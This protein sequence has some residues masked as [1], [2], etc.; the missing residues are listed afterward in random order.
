[1]FTDFWFCSLVAFGDFFFNSEKLKNIVLFSESSSL[2]FSVKKS[3]KKNQFCGYQSCMLM[4]IHLYCKLALDKYP[5]VIFPSVFLLNGMHLGN[6]QLYL[7]RS[8]FPCINTYM[9]SIQL[10]FTK[11][12]WVECP[13]RDQTYSSEVFV[14]VGHPFH[15]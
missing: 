9:K 1:M 5:N 7:G 15:L 3:N 10:V 13:V 2:N 14:R 4:L 6:I 12:L 11:L 8:S